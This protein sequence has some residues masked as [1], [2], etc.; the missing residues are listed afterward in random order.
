[1]KR[2]TQK[3]I[4]LESAVSSI[5]NEELTFTRCSYLMQH[6]R[7]CLTNQDTRESWI[8]SNLPEGFIVEDYIKIPPV[9]VLQD[10]LTFEQCRLE[11]SDWSF[12]RSFNTMALAIAKQTKASQEDIDGILEDFQDDC[13]IH[14]L[15]WEFVRNENRGKDESE[16][17]PF[18]HTTN[19]YG[20]RT[21]ES[22]Y[23]LPLAE[24]LAEG[25]ER[26]IKR[27]EDYCERQIKHKEFAKEGKN[28]EGEE[29]TDRKLEIL[30]EK[31]NLP[32]HRNWRRD[33][34]DYV[35]PDPATLGLK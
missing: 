17:E 33:N 23:P 20:E 25:R 22:F 29:Y 12:L 1:M 5:V 19:E 30:R 26:L 21:Y 3:R 7:E 10:D 16:L 32:I 28:G 24:K 8:R 2:R 15:K 11:M 4:E 9:R 34:P 18:P 13:M 6:I 27:Q 31:S 14:K 35:F